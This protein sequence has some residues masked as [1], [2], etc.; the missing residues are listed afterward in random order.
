MREDKVREIFQR[1][2]RAWG[3]Q[4]WWP[5]ET[6][7]EM[8]VGAY[9]TQNTAW[10]NVELALARLQAADAL[11]ID[12]VR[13]IPIADLEDLVRP[14]GYFRQKAARLKQFVVH[15]DAKYSSIASKAA[16]LSQH[17]RDELALRAMLARHSD[18]LRA[19]LLALNGVGPET[20]DSILLYA[21]LHPIFVVDAY[22]KRIFSRHHLVSEDAKY[23]DMRALIESALRNENCERFNCPTQAN[24][25][26]EWATDLESPA[27]EIA[28]SCAQTAEQE[29]FR[30]P[31]HPPSMLSQLRR[32]ETAQVFAEF[33]GL[34]VQVGKHFCLKQ[35]PRCEQC[36][37]RDSLP[38]PPERVRKA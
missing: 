13:R 33:H 32:S 1:L 28:S 21:G 14:A 2:H 6:K 10:T 31:V 19:E 8:I 27:N 25:G 15:L 22:T 23:E 34:L 37:L 11:N 29:P 4:H 9:L 20:A 24:N 12:G 3:P 16:G 17:D 7:F 18:E 38:K 5:A 26:P 30:P 35:Q 36:P